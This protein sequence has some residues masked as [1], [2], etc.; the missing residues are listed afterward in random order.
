MPKVF[1]SCI[2]EYPAPTDQPWDMHLA[3]EIGSKIVTV[4]IC[5]S[6]GGLKARFQCYF[7]E[8]GRAVAEIDPVTTGS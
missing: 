7:S 2:E 3:R 1:E 6:K 5:G 8:M 4:T